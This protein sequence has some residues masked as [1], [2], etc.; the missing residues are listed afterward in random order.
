ML[1]GALVVAIVA[2]GGV[3][4]ETVSYSGEHTSPVVRGMDSSNIVVT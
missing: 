2:G 4:G 3:P 1:A